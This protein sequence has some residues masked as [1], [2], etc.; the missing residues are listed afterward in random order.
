MLLDRCNASRSFLKSWCQWL[1]RMRVVFRLQAGVYCPVRPSPPA[2]ITGIASSLFARRLRAVAGLLIGWC[3]VSRRPMPA[4]PRARLRT[5]S[6]RRWPLPRR[7]ARNAGRTAI[8]DSIA[9][10]VVALRTPRIY[11]RVSN[12]LRRGLARMDREMRRRGLRLDRAQ[13]RLA[14][15]DSLLVWWRLGSTSLPPRLP[16]RRLTIID[17]GRGVSIRGARRARSHRVDLCIL[18]SILS[19][20]KQKRRLVRRLIFQLSI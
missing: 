3:S 9:Q 10:A 8:A 4:S 6:R 2:A 19:S 20:R 16:K 15:I 5:R 18:L 1:R 12:Q 13:R 14:S 17:R 7:W 11:I